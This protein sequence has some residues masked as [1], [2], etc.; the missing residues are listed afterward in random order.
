[1]FLFKFIIDIKLLVSHSGTLVHNMSTNVKRMD[2]R[3]KYLVY[4]YLNCL[5]IKNQLTTSINNRSTSKQQ[6]CIVDMEKNTNCE[7]NLN[8][9]NYCL[10]SGQTVDYLL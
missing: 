3:T 4:G 10:H 9:M 6:I 8:R 1:M 2:T 5:K 7:L